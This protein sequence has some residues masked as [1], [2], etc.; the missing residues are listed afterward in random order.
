MHY[1]I[2]QHNMNYKNFNCLK[3][4]ILIK[5]QSYALICLTLGFDKCQCLSNKTVLTSIGINNHDRRSL[6]AKTIMKVLSVLPVAEQHSMGE[7]I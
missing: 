7:K 5:N 2:L 6:D 3:I 4:Q 1:Y